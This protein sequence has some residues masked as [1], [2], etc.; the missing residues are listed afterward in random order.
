MKRVFTGTTFMVLI[1]SSIPNAMAQGVS[2]YGGASA[3]SSTSIGA[4]HSRGKALQDAAGVGQ[5]RIHDAIF[6]KS[7]GAGGGSGVGGSRSSNGTKNNPVRQVSEAEATAYAV[8]AARQYSLAQAAMKKGDNESALKLLSSVITTRDHVWGSTDPYLPELLRQQGD[9]YQK[10]GRLPDAI[11]SYK[12]QL[13]AEGKR[14]GESSAQSEKTTT[15]L[16]DVSEKAGNST[17]A[18]IFLKKLYDMQSRPGGNAA[19]SKKTMIRLCN[20]LTMKGDYEP[21]EAMLRD[22]IN[23]QVISAKPDNAFLIKLYDSYGGLLREMGRETEALA[24][25]KRAGILKTES[26]Q[27]SAPLQAVTPTDASGGSQMPAPIQAL[28]P[29]N[30]PGGSLIPAVGNASR[31]KK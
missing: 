14:F 3:S 28:T 26:S 29:K 30:A 18:S 6:G 7:G 4:L 9:V 20:A 8:S 24:I 11:N 2:E 21:A 23:E 25:E 10:L 22:R 27:V 12:K 16:V 31:N 1:A 17:D 5:S 13:M 19:G 15:M